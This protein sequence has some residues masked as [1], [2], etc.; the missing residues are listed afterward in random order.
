M[1][2]TEERVAIVTHGGFM[3]ALLKALFGQLPG[4]HI[5]YRHQNTAISRVSIP[6]S[7]PIEAR[8]LN[9]VDHLDAELVS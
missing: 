4:D 3:D 7:A 2:D 1:S 5:Y 8:C 6:A 9:R